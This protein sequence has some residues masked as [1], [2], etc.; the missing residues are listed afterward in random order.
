MSAV[1]FAVN[2]TRVQEAATKHT[3]LTCVHLTFIVAGW[4]ETDTRP[5]YSIRFSVRDETE[6]F[7]DFHETEAFQKHVSGPSRA[8]DFETETSSLDSSLAKRS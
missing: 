7:P 5:R 1:L 8:R 4:P 6:T 2:A 3:F